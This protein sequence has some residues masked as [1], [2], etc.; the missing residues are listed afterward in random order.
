MTDTELCAVSVTGDSSEQIL[1]YKLD[2]RFA[3]TRPPTYVLRPA[4]AR[5]WLLVAIEETQRLVTLGM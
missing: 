4:A 1:S 2:V 3:M 5:T